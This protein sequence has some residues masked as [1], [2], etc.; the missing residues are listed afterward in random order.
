M[1]LSDGFETFNKLD[2]SD[3][4]HLTGL[5]DSILALERKVGRRRKSVTRCYWSER[6]DLRPPPQPPEKVDARR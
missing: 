3:D 1:S 2:D 6:S 4:E 5:L